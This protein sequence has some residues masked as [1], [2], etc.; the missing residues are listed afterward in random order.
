MNL[1][2]V[3]YYFA[4]LLS[5]LE[6]PNRDEWI[7]DIVPSSWEKDP[8][9]I[10]N[11]KL[12][13]PGNLWYI[14]TI[15]NDDST[16]M[17]T[18]KVYDRAMPLD[19]NTKVD[20]FECRDQEALEINSSY[21]ESLFQD[22]IEKHPVSKTNLDL[23]SEM[24]DYVI[25]HFR[26]SFGNRIM[27]QLN[28]FVPVYVGCGGSEI[29]GI[30]YFIAKKILRKFDQL[31]VSFIRDEIDPFISYL[32]KRVGKGVMKECISYLETLKKSI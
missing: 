21:L 13:L 31:S 18:D 32:N 28:T 20:P 23:V 7:I 14:G 29:E 4:D 27:K 19:I 15:N 24:D 16:F 8:K 22:A 5:I 9:K 26:I 17:V 10:P 1:A 12:K 2:R 3:E 30:D 6:M 11:G 25:K